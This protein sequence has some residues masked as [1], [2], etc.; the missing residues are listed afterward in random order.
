MPI[1]TIC[2]ELVFVGM[3]N[4]ELQGRLRE[5]VAHESEWQCLGYLPHPKVPCLETIY[6]RDL[7][8]VFGSNSISTLLLWVKTCQKEVCNSCFS[9][10]WL[11]LN[12]VGNK[13]HNTILFFFSRRDW[14]VDSIFRYSK[15]RKK[16]NVA[17]EHILAKDWPKEDLKRISNDIWRSK[18][19][20]CVLPLSI[21][22]IVTLTV[23][24]QPLI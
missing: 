12:R 5:N 22:N 20:Q 23:C 13:K 14:T 8:L 24:L 6:A 7:R 16:C 17:S 2:L 3:W 19:M 11:L 9:A 15:W 1:E 10:A 21:P 4:G 18:L